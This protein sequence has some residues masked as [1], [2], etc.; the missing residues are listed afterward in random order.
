MEKSESSSA[1]LDWLTKSFIPLVC[2]HPFVKLTLRL[3]PVF[4]CIH[5]AE[6]I[7]AHGGVRGTTIGDGAAMRLMPRPNDP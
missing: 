2:R 5:Q 6:C 4:G 1:I 3:M 7:D